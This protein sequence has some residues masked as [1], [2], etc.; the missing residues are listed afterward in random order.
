MTNPDTKSHIP[1]SVKGVSKE[2]R[3]AAK[4]AAGEQGI[5]M[6]EWLTRAIRSGGD[7]MP[8]P[9][10]V[11]TQDEMASD[12][13]SRYSEPNGIDDGDGAALLRQG[14]VERIGQ[15]EK[16]ILNVVEPLQEII[17]QMALRI[18]VLE[19]RQV[20][21]PLEQPALTEPKSTAFRKAGW[22]D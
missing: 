19:E 13:V 16:R 18:E 15:S 10:P 8:N 3:E 20:A 22:D 21:A 11:V 2:A 6:G 12:S 17:Q 7:D 1:W 4:K 9:G 5:T 14:I